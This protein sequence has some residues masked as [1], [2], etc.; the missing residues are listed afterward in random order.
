MN[1]RWEKKAGALPAKGVKVRIVSK[2]EAYLRPAVP[3]VLS[4]CLAFAFES[5]LLIAVFGDVSSDM[6]FDMDVEVA[7][8][9]VAVDW[10][11]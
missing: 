5:L 4:D 7:L 10:M 8:G 11:S 6:R 1:S 3:V 2:M 9:I